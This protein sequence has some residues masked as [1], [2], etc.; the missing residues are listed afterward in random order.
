MAAIKRRKQVLR[1]GKGVSEE[2]LAKA[3]EASGG[4]QTTAAASLQPVLSHN[5][6]D[7]GLLF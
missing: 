4:I 5:L 1:S 7:C 6:Q 3:L 2:D